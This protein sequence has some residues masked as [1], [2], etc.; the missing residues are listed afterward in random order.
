[1]KTFQ[2]RSKLIALLIILLSWSNV[3]AYSWS[4]EQ[5]IGIDA[6]GNVVALWQT[7]DS[8][9]GNFVIQA[10]YLSFGGTWSAPTTLSSSSIESYSPLLAVNSRGDAVALWFIDDLSG[11][12]AIQS[13]MLPF[14]G[15]WSTPAQISLVP[16]I[17]TQNSDLRMNDNGNIVATWS[18]L[19]DSESVIRVATATMGGTWSDPVTISQ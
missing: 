4:E 9:S 2:N 7:V 17:I 5:K 8:V 1:M 19:V 16:Q 18:V 6:A 15:S 12:V 13:S 11:N 14:G 10:A 3:F